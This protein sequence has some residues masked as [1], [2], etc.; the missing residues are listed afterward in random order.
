MEAIRSQLDK[1]KQ[2][3]AALNP[4]YRISINVVAGIAVFSVCRRIINK[5][6]RK[7]HNLPPGSE[8][9]LHI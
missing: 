4:Y 5:L 6:H 7:I 3:Y 8:G 9:T 2:Y 1:L